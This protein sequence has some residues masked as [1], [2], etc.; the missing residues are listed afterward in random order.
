M[1]EQTFADLLI[2]YIPSV[3]K[4]VR[5]QLRHS[6]HADDVLQKTLLHA[7]VHRDQ[8][9]APSKFKSWLWSIAINEVRGF[10]R[11]ARPVVSLD[12]FPQFEL[13]DHEPSPHAAYERVEREG[14][15]RRAIAGLSHKDRTAIHLVDFDD[16]TIP[17]AAKSLSVSTSALKSTHFR[18]RRRLTRALTA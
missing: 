13:V 18:A 8:L 3:R 1:S 11:S 16:M 10:L 4:L 12:A 7:F 2:P 14:R 5:H 9:R 6:D 17:Q 15:L